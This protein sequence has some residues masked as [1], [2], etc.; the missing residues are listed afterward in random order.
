MRQYMRA[1]LAGLILAVALSVTSC[2]VTSPAGE[3][4]VRDAPP[5]PREE[6]IGVAPSPRHV[7]TPGYW[8]WHDGWVWEPGRWALRPYPAAGWVPGYWERRGR[9]WG[10]TS[11]HWR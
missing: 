10:W 8:A 3:V 2:A 5:P 7:W 1:A 11:G 4:V 6:V 9:R